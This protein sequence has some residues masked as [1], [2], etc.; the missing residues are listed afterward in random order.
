LA[1]KARRTLSSSPDARPP[2]AFPVKEVADVRV[3]IA[4]LAARL[5]IEPDLPFFAFLVRR[6]GIKEVRLEGDEVV[7][8]SFVPVEPLM[9]EALD[10]LAATGA[11]PL[12]CRICS[13]VHDAEHD[14]GIFA[15]PAE[16]DGFICRAC[17]EQMSAWT[18]FNDHLAI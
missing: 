8:T 10:E 9:R 13:T 14:D 7:Y 4:L 12:P 1:K 16:F 3:K 18:F 17:A 5:G 6:I 15:D 2:G 11:R